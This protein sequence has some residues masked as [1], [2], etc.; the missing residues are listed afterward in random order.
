MQILKDEV[1]EDIEKAA[2]E[3]FLVKGFERTSMQNIAKRAK[4]STSNIYNYFESKEKLFITIVDPVYCQINQLIQGFMEYETGQ[5]FT[6]GNF[7][8]EFI[9]TVAK[10]T[11]MFIKENHLQLLLI[12]DKSRGTKYEQLKEDLIKFLEDHFSSSLKGTQLNECTAF[13][14]H[15]SATNLVEGL[16]EIVRHYRSDAWADHTVNDFIRYHIRGLAQFFD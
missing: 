14:M 2:I 5:S 6:D 16:L 8:E 4:V 15:I 13:I 1:R 11:G 10:S 3:E 7:I 9:Q 12:F